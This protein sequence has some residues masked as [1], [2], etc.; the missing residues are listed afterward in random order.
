MVDVVVFNDVPLGR[1]VAVAPVP[2]HRHAR[3]AEVGN[4]VVRNLV[5]SRVEDGYAHGAGED[6]SAVLD[7]VVV[8][9]DV[10]GNLVAVL[11]DSGLAN[12]HSACA[13]VVYV[14]PF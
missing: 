8:N 13:Q 5:V 12:L 9:A 4:V 7:D 3:I 2:T 6:V 14:A 10:V 11:P 1:T